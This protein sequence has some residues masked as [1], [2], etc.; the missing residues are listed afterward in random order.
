MDNQD[1]RG[2]ITI[3]IYEHFCPSP[4]GSQKNC[5]I[6]NLHVT[7]TRPSLD[8]LQKLGTNL[9]L[10]MGICFHERIETYRVCDPVGEA[11]ELDIP[12]GIFPIWTVRQDKPERGRLRFG[13]R[14][15]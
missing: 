7:I 5:L 14:I 8:S 15:G 13:V 6:I 12:L 9:R 10:A 4:I 1:Q 11:Y 3:A 2:T